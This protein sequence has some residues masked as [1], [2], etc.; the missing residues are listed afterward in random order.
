MCISSL[1]F[2][3]FF[4]YISYFLCVYLLLVTELKYANAPRHAE[5][6]IY[7]GGEKG[8]AGP[9]EFIF[10]IQILYQRKSLT[11][12]NFNSNPYTDNKIWQLIFAPH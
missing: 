8:R 9:G 6:D 10:K 4:A 7:S 5:L 12:N 11:Q 2:S 3:L 1:F